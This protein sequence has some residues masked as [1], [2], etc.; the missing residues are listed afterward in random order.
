MR[1]ALLGFSHETNT[2]ATPPTGYDQWAASGILRGEEIVRRHATAHTTVA[3]YLEAGRELEPDVEV[4]PLMYAST[5]PSG[6]ITGD[7]YQRLTAELL[8]LLDSKGPWDG[9]LLAQHGA[10]VADGTPDADG[11]FARRAREV[12]GDGV[13]IGMS[14]DMHANVSHQMVDATTVM[15]VFRTNPHVDPRPRAR[16]CAELIVRTV[17]GEIRPV[18]ALETPPLVI[19]IVKQF[20][21]EPPMKDVMDDCAAAMARTGMLTASAI[22]G[23]PYADVA[24]M[25]MSFLAVHDGDPAAAREAARWMA[26]RA[27]ERRTAFVG[28]TPSSEEALRQAMAAPGGPVVVMDVGDNI[29]GGSP[30]DSTILLETARRLGVRSYLQTLFDPHAVEACVASGVGSTVSLEVGANTDDRHGRPV[31]V[32]G[33]VRLIS[34]G[35]FEEHRPTHGGQ[36]FFNAG[37]TAVLEADDG[38]TLVLTSRRVGNTSIEQMYSLGIRPEQKQVV[39]AKGVVSPRPAY[40]PIAAQIILANTPGVTTAD[41]STFEYHHRRRPLYPFESDASYDPAAG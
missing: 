34:D 3:G 31:T 6:T 32:T 22:E 15:V 2:F 39:V 10:A 25:G 36:R 9:V 12:V 38:V 1:L 41:L 21:G 5:E 18:Q 13:P 8:Q 19:N 20:T 30:A 23:Y 27:W 17:R 16:E 11:D 33:R 37:I 14:L 7:A 4:V 28:D 35:L 24:E 40:E 26:Q 29:G